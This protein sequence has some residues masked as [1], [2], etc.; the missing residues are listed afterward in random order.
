[1]P[2]Q[3]LKVAVIGTSFASAVQIP[4]FQLMPDVEVVAVASANPDRAA[5]TAEKFGIPAAYGDWRKMLDEV[6][7]DIVSIVTPPYLHREMALE[8]IARGRHIFCEKPFALSVAEGLEMVEAAAASGRVHAVDHEFRYRPA[9]SRMKELI[10]AGHLGEPRVIRWAWLLGMLA[11]SNSRAWDWWSERSKG[12]GVFGALGSHLIDS[13]LWWFGEIEAVSAQ[14]NTF[15]SR[16]PTKDGKGWGDVTADD[17]VALHLRFASG[18]RCSVDLTGLARPGKLMLEAYGSQ[19]ALA[20]E[21]DARLLTATGTG[22]WEAA[23]IPGRLVRNI[24]GD[25]RIAPFVELADR[26]V[27]RV[28]GEVTPDFADF[29]QGLR[30]QAVMDAAHLSAAERRTVT[31]EK[32]PTG[33]R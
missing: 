2:D 9:R 4:G 8:T 14:V 10:D 30:V 7:C 27:R 17:D 25:P 22:S 5:L 15:V 29:Y 33:P 16:R 28:R 23:E 21:D 18:A 26:L 1:M 19:G 13:L 3:P 32:T 31:V 11:E 20:I 24:Q 6:E 12:G